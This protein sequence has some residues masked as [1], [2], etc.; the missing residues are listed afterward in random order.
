MNNSASAQRFADLAIVQLNS[1]N[2]SLTGCFF[3]MGQDTT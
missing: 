3:G 1:T 2:T